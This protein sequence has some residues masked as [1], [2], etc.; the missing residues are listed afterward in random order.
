VWEGEEEDVVMKWEEVKA[1]RKRKDK[2]MQ[3]PKESNE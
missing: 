3:Y 2:C 1:R